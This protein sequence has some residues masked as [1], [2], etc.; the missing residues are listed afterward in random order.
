MKAVM[1]PQELRDYIRFMPDDE[2]V[3]ITI[4]YREAKAEDAG[5]EAYEGDLKKLEPFD[6]MDLHEEVLKIAR[7]NGYRLDFS[8]YDNML[9]GLPH[10]IE[11]VI[12][13]K[14]ARTKKTSSG[15]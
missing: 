3:S 7:N 2:V 6:F 13:R 8:A 15:R 1:T 5:E 11:G 4:E 12:K 14:R 10:V 9:V